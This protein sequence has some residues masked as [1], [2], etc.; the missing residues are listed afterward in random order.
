MSEEPRSWVKRVGRW[1]LWAGGVVLGTC[2][3]VWAMAALHFDFPNEHLRGVLPFLYAGMLVVALWITKTAVGRL[4][5]CVLGF[6]VVLGWWLTLKPSNTREWQA[7]VAQTPWAEIEGNRIT[8]H[9]MRDCTYRAEFE[10][11]CEWKTRSLDLTKIDGADLF[12]TYWGSPWIAHPIVSFTVAGE[13]PVAMSVET[14]KE[15]GETYS[16][17]RGFFRY[18]ELIYIISNER[19]VVRLRTNYRTGEDVYLFHTRTPPQL[20][21]AVFLD[22]LRR[23]NE[24]RN[25]P[26][27]YNALT[28]NCTT[29]VAGHFRDVEPRGAKLLPSWDWREMLNGKADEML[30]ENGDLATDGLSFAELKK[31]A[32]INGAAKA[33]ND[34]PDF[35]QRVRAGRP[36]F[37][38]G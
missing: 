25:K 1:S 33:A 7:D 13:D 22:Y 36:G 4:G 23:A 35:S 20:A 2:L 29:N 12:I 14:R 24:L 5:V 37:G 30:Y 26:E 19:D 15:V 9:N 32:H 8:I 21:Q 11:T 27:W 34:S 28:D 18:Y 17:V 38:G 3:T 16:A 10:Y 31:R 6:L